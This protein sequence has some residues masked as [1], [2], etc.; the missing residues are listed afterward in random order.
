[1]N[2]TA[3]ALARSG[4]SGRCIARASRAPLAYLRYVAFISCESPQILYFL[5]KA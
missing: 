5:R 4:G 1:M 2:E 3:G